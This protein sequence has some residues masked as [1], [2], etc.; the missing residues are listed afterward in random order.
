MS[1]GLITER[2][3]TFD[4]YQAKALRTKN[5]GD[6][7]GIPDLAVAGLGIA[8]EAGEVADEIKKVLGHGK[9]MDVDKLVKE[10]GDV[11]WYAASVAEDIGVPLSVIAARNVAK[12]EARYPNGFTTA[13]SV[14]KADEV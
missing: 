9:A 8:G 13:A 12:L 14:A 10:I 4:E 6:I 7:G 5:R 3:M 2:H 1:D 11:L